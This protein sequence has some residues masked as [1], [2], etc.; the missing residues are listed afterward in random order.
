MGDYYEELQKKGDASKVIRVTKEALGIRPLAEKRRQKST[1]S[2]SAPRYDTGGFI[3]DVSE[4]ELVGMFTGHQGRIDQVNDRAGVGLGPAGYNLDRFREGDLSDR[5]VADLFVH[6]APG[7]NSRWRG[8]D[9]NFTNSVRERATQLDRSIEAI[10]TINPELQYEPA[11]LLSIANE[12]F[13]EQRIRGMAKAQDFLSMRTEVARLMLLPAEHQR[14]WWEGLNRGA[15]EG[16]RKAGYRPPSELTPQVEQS[17]I[18]AVIGEA[19]Q[20]LGTAAEYT[21][22]DMPLGAVSWTLG[23]AFDAFG[24]AANAVNS[25]YRATSYAAS[26]GGFDNWW[27]LYNQAWDGER[28]IKPNNLE[29]VTEM[30]E[31][32]QA[33][34]DLYLRLAGGDSIEDIVGDTYELGTT[35]YADAFL[36][37]QRFASDDRTLNAVDELNRGKI[38]FGRDIAGGVLRLDQDDA[39]YDMASG[40]ADAAWAI[41]ADP[42]FIAGKTYKTYRLARWGMGAGRWGLGMGDEAV[43]ANRLTRQIGSVDGLGLQ[44]AVDAARGGNAVVDVHSA[45]YWSQLNK[46]PITSVQKR[47]VSLA[48]YMNA[49]LAGDNTAL[50]RLAELDPNV[51]EMLPVFQRYI[52]KVLPMTPEGAPVRALNAGDAV[53]FLRTPTGTVTADDVVEFG[54]DSSGLAALLE[55][56][57]SSFRHDR[58]ELPR[59]TTLGTRRIQAKLAMHKV[60]DWAEEGIIR[61]EKGERLAPDEVESPELVLAAVADQMRNSAGSSFND[62]LG[63]IKARLV[64]KG[65]DGETITRQLNREIVK[66][67]GVRIE[68]GETAGEALMRAIVLS[69]DE[70]AAMAIKGPWVAGLS[71]HLGDEA[72]TYID[73]AEDLYRR[74]LGL[75]DDVPDLVDRVTRLEDMVEAAA[76]SGSDRGVATYRRNYG[77][78]LAN[79]GASADEQADA[80]NAFDVM[81]AERR[82][83]GGLVDAGDPDIEQRFKQLVALPLAKAAFAPVRF[84]RSLAQQIPKENFLLLDGDNTPIVLEQFLNLGVRGKAGRE[85]FGQFMRSSEAGRRMVMRNLYREMFDR[86][87]ILDNPGYADFVQSWLES[88]G[89]RYGLNDLFQTPFGITAS[90]ILPDAHRAGAVAIPA[91]R[92]IDAHLKRGKLMGLL[93]GSGNRILGI[94][95][96]WADRLMSLWRISVVLRPAMVPRAAGEELLAQY[97]RWGPSH[98]F[99]QHVVAHSQRVDPLV[100]SRVS[101]LNTALHHDAMATTLGLPK[102]NKSVRNVI[103]HAGQVLSDALGKQLDRTLTPEEAHAMAMY[104]TSAHVQRSFGEISGVNGLVGAARTEVDKAGK[105]ELRLFNVETGQTEISKFRELHGYDS[106]DM[107][108]LFSHDRYSKRL[109]ELSSDEASRAAARVLQLGIAPEQTARITDLAKLHLPIAADDDADDVLNRLRLG[110]ANLDPEDREHLTWWLYTQRDVAPSSRLVSAN[111]WRAIRDAVDVDLPMVQFRERI[112]TMLDELD[113]NDRSALLAHAPDLGG[114]PVGWLDDLTAGPMYR[115]TRL[116]AADNDLL[117]APGRTWSEVSTLASPD[118]YAGPGIYVTS[119]GEYAEMLATP[120]GPTSRPSVTRLRWRDG[121]PPKMLTSDAIDESAEVAHQLNLMQADLLHQSTNDDA[122]GVIVGTAFLENLDADEAVR[123]ARDLGINDE[124]LVEVRRI[125]GSTDW[126]AAGYPDRVAMSV[127][128]VIREARVRARRMD[129]AVNR[130]GVDAEMYNTAYG[131]WMVDHF[132]AK[133]YRGVADHTGDGDTVAAYWHPGDLEVVS[134]APYAESIVERLLVERRARTARRYSEALAPDVDDRAARL[135]QLAKE[136]VIRVLMRPDRQHKLSRMDRGT[137]YVAHPPA[138]GHVRVQVPIVPQDVVA[139]IAD[140]VRVRGVDEGTAELG[141]LTGAAPDLERASVEGALDFG[142]STAFLEDLVARL[143]AGSTDPLLRARIAMADP[144]LADDILERLRSTIDRLA[145]PD[146]AQRVHLGYVDLRTTEWRQLADA[147]NWGSSGRT[148]AKVADDAGAAVAPGAAPFA[149][150]ALRPTL[151][152]ADGLR[153]IDDDSVLNRAVQFADDQQ[154]LIPSDGP[155]PMV[156][157]DGI[158]LEQAVDR[159]AEEIVGLTEELVA[160]GGQA[161]PGLALPVAEGRYDYAMHLLE[162]DLGKL[163]DQITGPMIGKAKEVNKLKAGADRGM[164]M[165][166]RGISWTSRHPIARKTF[167]DAYTDAVRVLRPVMTDPVVKSRA[168]QHLDDIDTAGDRLYETAAALDAAERG[169]RMDDVDVIETLVQGGFYKPADSGPMTWLAKDGVIKKITKRQE[170]TDPEKAIVRWWRQE[171][172]LRDEAL[173]IGSV[174][175]V[176]AAIPFI[177]DHKIRSQFAEKIRNVIPFWFAEEQFYKRWV[178]T[179]VHSPESFRRLSLAHNAVRS[180]GWTDENEYGEEVFTYPGAAVVGG[181]IAKFLEALPM[182]SKWTLPIAPVLQGQLS[183]AAPG[184]DNIAVPSAGPLAAIPLRIFRGIMPEAAMPIE[185]AVLGERGAGRS[186]PENLL[187]STVYRLVNFFVGD[188]DDLNSATIGAMQMLEANHPDWVPASDAST[189]EQEEYLERVRNHARVMLLTKGV[190]GAIVPATPQLNYDP[191]GFSEQF[192]RYLRAEVPIDVA[193]ADFLDDNP[194][195]TPYTIFDSE[196]PSKAAPDPTE[197]VYLEILNNSDFYD[198]HPDAGPWLLPAEP[199]GD[200]FDRRAWHEMLAHKMRVRKSADEFYRDLKFK[201]AAGLY[202][203]SQREKDLALDQATSTEQRNALKDSWRQWSD[204]YMRLHPIF[205]EILQGREGVER[206]EAIL[207]D[208]REALVDENA[209]DT[210]QG[211]VITELISSYDEWKVTRDAS[212]S[213]RSD[214]ATAYRERLTQSFIEW[215]EDFAAQ[216]STSLMFWRRVLVQLADPERRYSPDVLATEKAA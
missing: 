122:L 21:G 158:T 49:H 84:T 191:E 53:R 79:R 1:S 104:A 96:E 5:Q 144:T 50:A 108:E 22:L 60:I 127:G 18:G 57:W 106:I 182:D 160:P 209:P 149:G 111:G 86:M 118:S 95:S 74:A 25:A 133:G 204:E 152:E 167:T 193:I 72:Q 117:F 61:L 30:A 56:K 51:R 128:D 151:G 28:F 100:R 172:V 48:D 103:H 97:A 16:Y 32:N 81:V 110:F 15:Q 36:A 69:V 147:G 38:S 130:G 124:G 161:I 199:G 129:R 87:G 17:G 12:P 169:Y 8:R 201:E 171:K 196:S 24:D 136:E 40:A 88:T 175:S 13:L 113:Y 91:F 192:A 66:V 121:A 102:K 116:Q 197:E 139:S 174:R 211:P 59:L 185:Q 14:L 73:E 183:Y 180:A 164:D 68:P 75:N 27:T 70:E 47:V 29:R 34:L 107:G 94:N 39:F 23:T 140:R 90:G 123:M 153:W 137:A 194:D 170:L 4:D 76:R 216:D 101:M 213:D 189:A 85:I 203:E 181:T 26:N 162:R 138:A 205:K 125:V 89:Q 105:Y 179:F 67:T 3:G 114:V 150:D 173:Q 119:S 115:G 33:R 7:Q 77:K 120:G 83:T 2:G 176:Q 41:V 19:V 132:S 145:G 207:R 62:T 78:S 80:L 159:W 190:L 135:R 186:L 198:A 71:V 142:G 35:E 177:D 6:Q 208:M 195:A 112:V 92:E 64:D 212:L 63:A 52:E 184:F 93:N 46:L 143:D 9:G 215:G 37:M 156:K 168:A 146:A 109:V 200:E 163:P 148:A 210:R 134:E 98:L 202:F 65:F 10:L 45:R 82:T 131:K 188:E 44:Q 43:I 54:H 165:I 155:V 187:P 178:R 154:A 206:R 11:T 42:T 31:G 214:R 55:G 141:A 58:V 157:A 20:K 166:G 99:K 126:Q